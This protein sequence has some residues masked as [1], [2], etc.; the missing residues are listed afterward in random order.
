MKAIHVLLE[1][2]I[3]LKY[4]FTN[5]QECVKWAE[6]RLLHD[7]EENDEDIILLSASTDE[8][9]IKE[10]SS[11]ILEKYIDK[12]FL[13]EEYCAGKFIVKLYELYKSG[14]VGIHRLDSIIGSLYSNLNYPD[15]LAVL[16]SN[17]EYATD[18]KDF[19][20]HFDDEFSYIY[21]IWKNANSVGEFKEKYNRQVSSSHDVSLLNF[22]EPWYRKLLRWIFPR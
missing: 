7:E 19:R 14:P 10:L 9:E 2:F 22:E 1:A 3:P 8:R 12:Q 6:N 4:N 13:E 17:C 16:S 18:M 11:K 21:K 15:W 20:K 5:G